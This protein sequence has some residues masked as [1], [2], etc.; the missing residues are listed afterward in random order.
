MT[1]PSPAL[2][3]HLCGRPPVGVRLPHGDTDVEADDADEGDEGSD[4]V[5]EKHDDHTE[6]RAKQRDPLVIVPGIQ[7]TFRDEWFSKKLLT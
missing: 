2:A 7:L 1:I 4:V 6:K 5:H 3:S